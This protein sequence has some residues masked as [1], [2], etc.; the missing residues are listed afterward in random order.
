M[1]ILFSDVSLNLSDKPQL[2]SD[3]TDKMLIKLQ[4]A[5]SAVHT[6]QPVTSSLEELYQVCYPAFLYVCK[7]SQRLNLT[8][9]LKISV[10]TS[11]LEFSMSD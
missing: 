9:R 10:L 4:E 3:Y 6:S 5:I 7:V 2:P 1:T 8:R 11:K